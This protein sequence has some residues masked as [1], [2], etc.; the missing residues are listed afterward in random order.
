MLVDFVTCG[1]CECS[2]C[3]RKQSCPKTDMLDDPCIEC[4]GIPPYAPD[5]ANE[6][7][8]HEFAC[9]EKKSR[10]KAPKSSEAF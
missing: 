4:Y 2:E 8:L 1:D 7:N 5:L 3:L 9:D 10:F 6:D